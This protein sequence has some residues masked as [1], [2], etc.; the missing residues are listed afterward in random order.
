M[1]G[2]WGSPSASC[3]SKM[4]RSSVKSAGSSVKSPSTAKNRECGCH[5]HAEGQDGFPCRFKCGCA[6][7]LACRFGGEDTCAGA[8]T[9][10][11][12]RCG[13]GETLAG[14]RTGPGRTVV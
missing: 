2:S 4:A 14:G 5:D 1:G 10:C 3:T 11:D 8:G 7:H 6:G 12:N 13:R 9:R